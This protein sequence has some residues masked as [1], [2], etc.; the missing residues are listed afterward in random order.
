MS[1]Y[2]SP[3]TLVLTPIGGGDHLPTRGRDHLIHHYVSIGSSGQFDSG[4]CRTNGRYVIQ[5]DEQHVLI[6]DLDNIFGVRVNDFEHMN[7]LSVNANQPMYRLVYSIRLKAR[8]M[9]L[10]VGRDTTLSMLVRSGCLAVQPDVLTQEQLNKM[11]LTS[12]P[13]SDDEIDP[14]GGDDEL[15]P[16]H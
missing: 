14:L 9:Q 1:T 16:Y 8:D 13:P 12:P 15:P 7:L 5:P 2:A 3:G 6:T 11:L 4:L 10:H